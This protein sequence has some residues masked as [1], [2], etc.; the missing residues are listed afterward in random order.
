MN[1]RS[2]LFL[3]TLLAFSV[4]PACESGAGAGASGTLTPTIASLTSTTS[5]AEV[6]TGTSAVVT[7]ALQRGG[8]Y[9][10]VIT[11]S[12]D[13]LPASVTALFNPPGAGV[14]N[15]TVTLRLTAGSNAVAGTY[16]LQVRAT[17]VNVSPKTIPLALTVSVPGVTVATS[18][19]SV[20]VDTL[21]TVP[22]T[23]T[24]TGG[25]F[26]PVTLSAFNLPTGMS[27][28]FSP[29]V[30]ATGVTASIMT[31]SAAIGTTIGANPIVIRATAIG[32]VDVRTTV[33]VTVVDATQPT[34]R[35]SVA[36]QFLDASV[37][38]TVTNIISIA[39]AGG[40]A[41]SANLTWEGAPAGVVATF[42]PA[43]ATSTSA[44]SISPAITTVEG[45]YV[46]TVRGKVPALADR[47][48]T[49][50]LHVLQL[51]G[52]DVRISP[53]SVAVGSSRNTVITYVRQGN[54]NGSYT[55]TLQGL[56]PGVTNNSVPASVVSSA[57]INATATTFV[58]DN[59]AVPGDYLLTFRAV[60][61]DGST[62]TRTVIMTVTN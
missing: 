48:A 12:V 22:I 38:T 14:Q 33:P 50:T 2:G 9:D 7:Y 55:V 23:I 39:R 60:G 45:N 5:A 40:F 19:I 47:T 58:A 30:L 36:S 6:A 8:S 17:G 10:G 32:N 56:P 20:V 53:F 29:S 62:T 24:R 41:G 34:F 37:N 25:L 13:G 42:A 16:N 44:I 46:V 59:T 61:A 52:V 11:M 21:V 28:T 54:F 51:P 1:R 15:P 31:L 49:F 18:A 4:L 27:A 35:L 57:A 3:I 26:D 43:A